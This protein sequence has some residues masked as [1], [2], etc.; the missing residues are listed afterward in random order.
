MTAI[1]KNEITG[2]K[3][4]QTFV[5]WTC[6]WEFDPKPSVL[7]YVAQHFFDKLVN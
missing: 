4:Y 6:H 1:F 7:Y 2:I 3:S 5:K